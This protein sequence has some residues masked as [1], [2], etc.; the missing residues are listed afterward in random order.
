M[1]CLCLTSRPA[2]EN[3]PQGILFRILISCLCLGNNSPIS[4]AY[5]RNGVACSFHLCQSYALDKL[6]AGHAYS[7]RNSWGFTMLSSLFYFIWRTEM[8]HT[9]THLFCILSSLLHS[10]LLFTCQVYCSLYT[11]IQ[12]LS[13]VAKKQKPFFTM[14]AGKQGSEQ[15]LCSLKRIFNIGDVIL[16]CVQCNYN[17][18]F[19]ENYRWKDLLTSTHQSLSTI[20]VRVYQGKSNQ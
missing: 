19:W 14:E 13:T 5:D 2:S 1:A 12:F 10:L 3:R 20:L 7:L 9:H 11:K 6:P 8:S 17:P 16:D 18:V 4:R 15:R